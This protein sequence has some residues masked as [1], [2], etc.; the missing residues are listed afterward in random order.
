MATN[1]RAGATSEQSLDFPPDT[2]VPIKEC[3]VDLV[4]G[5]RDA[6]LIARDLRKLSELHEERANRQQSWWLQNVPH[7]IAWILMIAIIVVLLRAAI[8][9]LLHAIGEFA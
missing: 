8:S 3:V 9:P 1:V 7:W 2:P 6:D 5:K 4:T